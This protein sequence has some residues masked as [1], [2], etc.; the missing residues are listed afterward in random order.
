MTWRKR[1]EP[2]WAA[3]K[4]L[5]VGAEEI[6]RWRQEL[7]TAKNGP[8][9]VLNCVQLLSAVFKHARRFKWIPANPCEDVRKPRYKVKVRAFTAAEGALL[10]HYA[11]TPDPM[12]TTRSALRSMGRFICSGTFSSRRSFNPAPT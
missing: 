11:R 1:V 4:L 9:T 7:L 10:A 12:R 3:R 8:K 2:R 6:A 5:S